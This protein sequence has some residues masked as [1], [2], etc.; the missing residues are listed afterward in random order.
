MRSDDTWRDSALASN[1]PN[2]QSPFK[3]ISDACHDVNGA[4]GRECFGPI[5]EDARIADEDAVG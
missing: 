3:P 1:R 4:L 2:I 5:G